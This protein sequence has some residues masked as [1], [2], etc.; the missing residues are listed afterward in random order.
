MYGAICSFQGGDDAGHGGLCVKGGVVWVKHETREPASRVRM[1][2]VMC[3]V[4]CGA[5]RRGLQ[6]ADFPPAPT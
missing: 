3:D 5:V 2:D 4:M 1:A 6:I